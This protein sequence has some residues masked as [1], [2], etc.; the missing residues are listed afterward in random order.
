MPNITVRNMNKMRLLDAIGTEPTVNYGEIAEDI[1][2]SRS[3]V[4]RWMMK[5]DD[6]QTQRMMDAIKRIKDRKQ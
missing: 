1:G 5:P 4:A 3:T 2:V 6:F